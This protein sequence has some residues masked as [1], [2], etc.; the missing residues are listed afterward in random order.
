M[1]EVAKLRAFANAILED[2][3]DSCPDGFDIQ[4]LAVK[5]GLLEPFEVTE[6]CDPDSCACAEFGDFP[7][8]CYRRTNVLTGD[9]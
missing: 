4:D 6:P 2:F 8:S 3:P 1:S 5:H 9:L 7:M